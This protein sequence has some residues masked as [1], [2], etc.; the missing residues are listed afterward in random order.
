LVIDNFDGPSAFSIRDYMPSSVQGHIIFTT[1]SGEARKLGNHIPVTGMTDEE[2]LDLLMTCGELD[3]TEEINITEGAKIIHRLGNMPL[4]IDLA[5]A[6]LSGRAGLVR[7]QDFLPRYNEQAEE[8]MQVLPWISDYSADM[9]QNESSV[10]TTWEMMDYGRRAAHRPVCAWPFCHSPWFSD[11]Q[12]PPVGRVLFSPQHTQY[13]HFYRYCTVHQ[14]M[15]VRLL[16]PHTDY[17]A[18]KISFLN[19]FGFFNCM[20]IQ[21]SYST[22]TIRKGT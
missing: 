9:R 20:N 18:Q 12:Q 11:H 14:E 17:G 5:G 7:I 6:Y 22:H 4:A 10:F 1:R 16:E 19:I 13:T 2:A 21:K 8:I 3:K 15:M